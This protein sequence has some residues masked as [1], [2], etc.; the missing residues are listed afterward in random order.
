VIFRSLSVRGFR[1]YGMVEQTLNLPS[2]LAAIWGPNSKGKSS[3]AEAFEFL[4]TGCLSRRELM[5]SSQDEFA[6][7]I[8]NVHLLPGTEVYVR[9]LIAAAD[10]Q[11]RVVKRVLTTDY[12]KKQ[13]CQ[14]RLE[15]DGVVSTEADFA[16]LGFRLSHP[17]MAA[18]VLAQH[19]LSYIFSV[20]PQN[21]TTHFK[22]LLEVTDLDALRNEIAGA[23]AQLKAAES[24]LLEKLDRCSGLPG[25]APWLGT[26]R[27]AIGKQGATTTRLEGAAATLIKGAGESVPAS[28]AERLQTIERI[29]ADRRSKA[30]PVAGFK[31]S[32]LP[33]WTPITQTT[34]EALDTYVRE[35][36]K[37]TVETRRLSALFGE[38]LKLPTVDEIRAAIQ[39]PVCTTDASLTPARVQVIRAHVANTNEWRAAERAA[40]ASLAVLLMA[41]TTLRVASDSVL[42]QFWRQTTKVRR[43]NGFTM[44]RLRTILDARAGDVLQPWFTAAVRLVR[45]AGRLRTAATKLQAVIETQSDDIESALDGAALRP[46]VDEALARRVDVASALETYKAPAQRLGEVLN[47]II[48]AQSS[49]GWQDFLDVAREP[50]SLRR[51]LIDRQAH[52]KVAQELDAA[53]SQIDK[54]KDQV[55]EDKFSEYSGRIQAWWERL[56]PDEPTFFA[57]VRPRPGAKRTIDFK[58]GLSPN[59]DRTVPKVR[60]VIAVFSQS[61]LHCLGLSLFLARAEQDGNGFIVL[62]DPVLSSDED[63][64]VHFN[65]TVIEA[66]LD[67]P[68]QVIVITQDHRT[69][70]ELDTR[71]RH[72]GISRAQLLLDDPRTGTEIE[73]T[74]EALLAMLTRATSL[75]RGGHPDARKSCGLHLRDAGERFCKEVLV[76]ED[77][78]KGNGKAGLADYDGKVLEWL[79]PRVEPLLDGDP[80]HP[81]KLEAFRNA[82]NDAC[83][84]NQPPSSAAMKQA[85]G[86]LKYL[87]KQYLNLA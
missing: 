23:G 15:I 11:E 5:A 58:A 59:P 20:G 65:A 74:S 68:L 44:A 16:A 37:V 36:Q 80:S 71:Y 75:A 42:P 76:K 81:G 26:L 6:D 72:R 24:P 31:R 56:R 78:A 35:R 66:L 41:A 28:L 27:V 33:S 69:W 22:A 3:L 7:S 39:C 45:A 18:P 60:D 21:R 86:E 9:A 57:A 55:L 8:R 67:L 82:V 51:A 10:G 49:A 43:E 54:A 25:L 48:D 1:A 19:T 32:G 40:K 84:D 38:L 12:G 50:D 46:A 83:H 77:K 63:Y 53:L 17:P 4:L 34:W 79:C 85:C 2:E 70:T 73:N 29:V 13:N 52:A 30:F 61:Q 87:V 47:R 62:D 64:R 14:S